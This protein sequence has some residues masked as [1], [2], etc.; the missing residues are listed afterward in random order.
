MLRAAGHKSTSDN[1]D[2]CRDLSGRR[3]RHVE[4]EQKLAEWQQG[5]EQ[6]D[7]EKLALKHVKKMEREQQQQQ[8]QGNGQKFALSAEDKEQIEREAALTLEN[9]SAAVQSGTAFCSPVSG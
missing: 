8:Q 2:A 1:K 7:L 9:T 6:R 5:K 3:I 4:A